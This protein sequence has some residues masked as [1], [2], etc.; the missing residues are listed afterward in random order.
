[1]RCSNRA[2]VPPASRSGAGAWLG[3]GAKVLDGTTV[4]DAAIVGAGAVVTSDVPAGA[5]AVGV[6]A[7]V[8]GTTDGAAHRHEPPVERAAGLRS[9]R[10]GRIADAR[11]QAPVRVDDPALRSR[12]ASTCRSVSL[13]KKDLSEETLDVARR[14]HRV[15]APLEVRSGDAAGPAEDH[16]PQADRHPAPARLRCDDVRPPGRRDAAAADDSARARQ[17]HRHALVPEGRRPTARAVHRPRDRGLEEHGRFRASTRGWCRPRRSRSSTSAR[18][19]RSSA[20]ARTPDE[21]A[22]ARAGHR[23]SRRTTLRSARS[24][25]CTTRRATSFSSM[26]PPQV[27]AAHPGRRFFLAGEGPLR[28][29]ARGAG[30]APWS[31][32]SVRV[33][34]LPEG[35]RADACRRSTSACSPRSGRARR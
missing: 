20:A 28:R 15:P 35:R 21:I 22:A 4:G 30:A 32:R 8:V 10:L 17:P 7:K 2:V 33:P 13:R 14:R 11:R 31:R 12:R 26:R 19:S 24:R 25:A 3:A 9:P 5:I 16:R 6:P 34:R 1:M 18:R 29:V 27:V 23:R